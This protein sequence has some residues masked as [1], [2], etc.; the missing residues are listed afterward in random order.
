MVPGA[1]TSR[2]IMEF[3]LINPNF[4]AGAP[5]SG[6]LPLSI[7]HTCP[8]LKMPPIPRLGFPIDAF[9]PQ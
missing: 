4:R 9:L 1:S 2:R 5:E 8:L 3:H 6:P 7:T